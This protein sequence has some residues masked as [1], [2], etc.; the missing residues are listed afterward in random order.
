MNEELI[1]QTQI[2]PESRQLKKK[3]KKATV[4]IL[5][6][7]IFSQV[8]RVVISFSNTVFQEALSTYEISQLY[9][10]F[11]VRAMDWI[12]L[13]Q[14]ADHLLMKRFLFVAHLCDNLY[15][16]IKFRILT[17]LNPAIKF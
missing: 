11:K 4:F 14:R 6:S 15:P 3:K 12:Q 1:P 2:L 7:N 16:S 5:V 8:S 10:T 9:P 17:Q 13:F